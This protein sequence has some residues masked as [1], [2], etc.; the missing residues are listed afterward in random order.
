MS[1]NYGANIDSPFETTF[2]ES[3]PGGTARNL[4]MSADSG[5][6]SINVDSGATGNITLGVG[7][8]ATA[9]GGFMDL[10]SNLNIAH[11][12]AG[13]LLINRH[14]S[15]AGTGYTKTGTGTTRIANTVDNSFTGAVNVNQGRLIVAATSSAG[16]DLNSASA[17]NLG[18]GILEIRTTSALGKTLSPNITVSSAST[19]AYNNTTG[20]SQSLTIQTGTMAV[21]SALTLQNIS[22][23]TTLL[24]AVN[25]TRNVTGAGNV[26]VDTYN[27]VSAITDN[28]TL[29]RIQL[30]GNNSGW[31]GNFVIAKGTGQLAATAA[32]AGT[33]SI[34]IGTTSDAFGAGL[35]LNYSA[36]QTLTNSITVTTGGFR[37]IRNVGSGSI[38]I[39]L[40]GAMT[41]NGDLT[42]DHS[43]D[44]GRTLTLGGNISGAGGLTIARVGGSAG[45]TA[46]L[47][48]TNT[49]T[50]D[51]L[52]TSGSLILNGSVTSDVSVDGSSRIGGD[53]SVVGELS[54]AAG[55]TFVFS[56][57]STLDVN[58]AVSLD[59]TFGV[60]SLVNQDGTAIDWTGVG[61][62]TYT[63]IGVTSSDFSNIQNFGVS[64]AVDVGGGKSAYFQN[65]SLQLMVVP[66]PGTWAL[67]V[68]GLTAL[69]VFRRRSFA[70]N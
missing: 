68:T 38:D 65:G 46:V 27:N 16:G 33:G 29:G 7:T 28:F 60:A 48:G 9:G 67:L 43:L 24:N 34:T 32:S 31:S 18:G 2:R 49:Y 62:G 40:N 57:T 64:N 12:G 56:L 35:A 54:L 39:A 47:T 25:V 52:V 41:L 63:L 30:Q 26:V 44:S 15:G 58:G 59:N 37:G 36:S 4:I 5:N 19:L 22:A 1:I 53:G 11:N 55:A 50:G 45:S 10:L 8:G 61:L 17:V 13:E 23:D 51:T 21:N 3:L 14:I 6:A 20:T 66:E 69:I 42:V 70:K